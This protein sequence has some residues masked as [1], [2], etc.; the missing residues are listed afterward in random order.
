MRPVAAPPCHSPWRPWRSYT[1]RRPT[2][3]PQAGVGCAKC[4]RAQ[5]RH[6]HSA[7]EVVDGAPESVRPGGGIEPARIE[8][9][10]Q[11]GELALGELARRGDP[12]LPQFPD[13]ALPVEVFP[14]L[15]VAH[16]TDGREVERC[17]MA[18][19]LRQGAQRPHLVEETRGKHRVEAPGDPP[20]Q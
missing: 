16:R 5:T 10:A 13:V 4:A 2:G 7:D 3:P 11:P 8:L 20:V 12:P 19:Q 17:R 14:G 9:P 6:G 15:A 1:T 18:A